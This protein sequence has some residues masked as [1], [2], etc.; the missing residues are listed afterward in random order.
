MINSLIQLPTNG[1][2]CGSSWAH[3]Y[4]YKLRMIKRMIPASEK[5]T[6]LLFRTFL[7]SFL[8]LNWFNLTHTHF[9]GLKYVCRMFDFMSANGLQL[10]PVF[11]VEEKAENDHKNS[12]SII[13][14]SAVHLCPQ[15]V[16]NS[17][18]FA[19]TLRN[20]QCPSLGPKKMYFMTIVR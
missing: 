16:P 7:L 4:G 1:A 20:A 6:T 14:F 15:C 17:H 8:L 18:S 12:C 9:E 10:W 3:V 11:T 2:C 5:H 19:K 13:H